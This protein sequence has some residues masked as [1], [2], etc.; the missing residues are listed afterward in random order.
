[1]DEPKLGFLAT[2]KTFPHAFRMGCGVEMWERLAYYAMRSVLPL[3]IAQADDPGG[4]HF[5]QAQ[6]GS[7][8]AVW[9]I[10]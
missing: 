5:S 4:L 7:I 9:T 1:M 2:L 10:D 3:Y 8:I 6:K